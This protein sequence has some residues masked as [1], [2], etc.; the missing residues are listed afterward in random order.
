MVPEDQIFIDHRD[1]GVGAR[2]E[3][4]NVPIVCSINFRLSI[5]ISNDPG[6]PVH[7]GGSEDEAEEKSKNGRFHDLK[8]IISRWLRWIRW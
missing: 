7:E 1:L 8:I 2:H 5:G 3:T 4:N 6:R